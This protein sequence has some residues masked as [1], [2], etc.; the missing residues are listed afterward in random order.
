MI[1]YPTLKAVER[2]YVMVL[3]SIIWLR[4]KGL[5]NNVL[6]SVAFI[7]GIAGTDVVS[8]ETVAIWNFEEHTWR[9]GPK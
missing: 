9:A 1:S 6:Y 2:S 8:T 4:K 3:S 5:A 7:G